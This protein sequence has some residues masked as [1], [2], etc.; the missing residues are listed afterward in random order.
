MPRDSLLALY[1]E[2]V[3]RIEAEYQRIGIA[4]E[5]ETYFTASGKDE[6]NRARFE[7]ILMDLQAVP[8]GIGFDAYCARIGLDAN[9]LR[10]LHNR[11]LNDRD[12]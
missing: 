12:V 9:A 2:F 10:E 7:Q 5:M 3:P 8:S 6:L 4:S 11:I 1:E